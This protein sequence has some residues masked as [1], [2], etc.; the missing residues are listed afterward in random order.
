[1]W[2]F[3]YLACLM[4]SHSFIELT[5]EGSPYQYCLRCGKVEAQ[6]LVKESILAEGGEIMRAN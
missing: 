6:D 3:K 5:W 4:D 2:I 1:M